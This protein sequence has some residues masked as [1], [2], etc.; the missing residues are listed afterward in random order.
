M[1][2]NALLAVLMLCLLAN[3]NIATAQA[4]PAHNCYDTRKGSS[5]SCRHQAQA[6]ARAVDFWQSEEGRRLLGEG[7]LIESNP[8]ADACLTYEGEYVRQS[9]ACPER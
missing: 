4:T 7:R 2:L 3:P 5:R 8:N 1:A 6:R 9:K